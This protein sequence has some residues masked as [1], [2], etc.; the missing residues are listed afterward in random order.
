MP[1]QV[2]STIDTLIFQPN[3]PFTSITFKMVSIKTLLVFLAL[4]ADVLAKDTYR[5]VVCSTKLGTKFVKYPST[6]TSTKTV[7]ATQTEKIYK[8]N[9][10]T[11]TPRAITTTVSETLTET[12]TTTAETETDTATVTETGRTAHVISVLFRWLTHT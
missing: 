3:P 9:D 5:P 10:V 4:G 8:R 6:K 12:S 1:S 2:I 11:I 7:Y